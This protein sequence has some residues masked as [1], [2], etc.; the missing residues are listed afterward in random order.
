MSNIS[1]SLNN[2]AMT[3]QFV[4]HDLDSIEQK[5]NIDFGRSYKRTIETDQD[6]YPQ[7]EQD[8]RKEAATMAPHYEVFYSLE[9]T[10]RRLIVD[11]LFTAE[12]ANW[13]RS[14]RIPID[15]RTA[16]E[17]RQQK[18]IDSAITPRSDNG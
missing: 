17:E 1:A 7:I 14:T 5:F 3:I 16:I 4:E 2:F 11:S 8:I 13:W 10:V 6:Y 15:L 18:E 9:K 12:G